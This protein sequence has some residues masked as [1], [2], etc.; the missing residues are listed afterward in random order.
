MRDRALEK[1]K[2]A[3]FIGSNAAFL[4]CLMCGINFSWDSNIETAGVTETSFKWNPEW[5]DSLMSV[6]EFFF[7]NYGI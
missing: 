4:G 1:V 3:V 6:R 2:A 7:M 5:F